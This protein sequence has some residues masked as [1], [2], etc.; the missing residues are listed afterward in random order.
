[1]PLS[2]SQ[3]LLA[4]HHAV[5]K[6]RWIKAIA[7]VS[8]FVAAGVVIGVGGTLLFFKNKM[9]RVPP[10]RDA[11]VA[12]MVEKMGE[13]VTLTRDEEKRLGELMEGYFDE[14][15]DV[16]KESFQS[17]KAIF[18]RMDQGIESI[19]GPER[20]KV[21]YDYKEKKMAER[22]RRDDRKPPHDGPPPPGERGRK[23][24]KGE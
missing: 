12:S 17:V 3:R 6:R 24:K 21:W 1:M 4:R 22:W 20:F 18:K 2:D 5:Q 11:I 14:I 19:L 15:E 13:R 16:R 9:H 8:L 10:K 7:F 23:G